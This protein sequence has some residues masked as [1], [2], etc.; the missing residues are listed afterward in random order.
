M[1][2]MLIRRGSLNGH[3]PSN[4]TTGGADRKKELLRNRPM[5]LTASKGPADIV[6]TDHVSLRTINS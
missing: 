2:E 4:V 6:E 1:R 3:L 5:I